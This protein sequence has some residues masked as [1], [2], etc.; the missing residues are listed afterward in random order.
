MYYRRPRRTPL[1]NFRIFVE[2]QERLGKVSCLSLWDCITIVNIIT[3]GGDGGDN[4]DLLLC[5]YQY[6]CV[7]IATTWP[8]ESEMQFQSFVSAVIEQKYLVFPLN[9]LNAG[10]YSFGLSYWHWEPPF[11]VFCSFSVFCLSVSQWGNRSRIFH[12]KERKSPLQI[13]HDSSYGFS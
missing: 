11:S 10:L 1:S 12:N 5:F 2:D 7:L 13:R 3:Q 6:V 9:V 8:V 4:S